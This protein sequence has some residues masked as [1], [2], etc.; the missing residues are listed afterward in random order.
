METLMGEGGECNSLGRES[1]ILRRGKLGGV[2]LFQEL[3][4]GQGG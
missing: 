2:D 3:K 4:E 1:S